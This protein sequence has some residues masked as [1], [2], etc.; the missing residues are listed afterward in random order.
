LAKS[1]LL[2]LI[3]EI[4]QIFEPSRH[5][6]FI[7]LAVNS[8][9][10]AMGHLSVPALRRLN[11]GSWLTTEHK[12]K[13]R[14]IW[15]RR[16][17]LVGW[18]L[19]WCTVILLPGRFVT[20]D[21]WDSSYKL[22]IGNEKS[23][24]RPWAGELLYAAI[25][26]RALGPRE[27][28]QKFRRHGFEERTMSGLSPTPL[29]AY[30]FTQADQHTVT[31]TG[32]VP[33]S[34]LRIDLPPGS[35]WRDGGTPGLVLR[36]ELLATRGPAGALSAAIAAND[37]FS[38]EVWIRPA[39]LSQSGPARIIG[40]SDSILSRNF[41]LSQEEDGLV[42][43]V[44]NRFNGPNGSDYE[45]H[46]RGSLLRELVHVVATYDQGVSSIFRNGQRLGPIVDQREPSY[47]LRLGGTKPLS[48]GA[49]A[50]L[51]ALSL[52]A[53]S[54]FVVGERSQAAVMMRMFLVGYSFLLAPVALSAFLPISVPLSLQM[55]FG[56]AL[57]LSWALLTYTANRSSSRSRGLDCRSTNL[58]EWE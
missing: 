3:L 7:D 46:A 14:S 31:P 18:G 50:L 51:A 54:S 28:E 34:N 5:P 47:L 9:G 55:W 23:G 52:L 48:A 38:V 33:T 32:S 39:N 6:R 35:S 17:L 36:G 57:V 27:V 37:A 19:S 1:L 53:I 21:E 45:L 24:D 56:P 11:R 8:I 30:D 10:L 20:L 4:G 42:F 29:A 43:R 44:R 2:C 40:I 22:F 49:A 26:D 12:P 15:L 58:T 25:Y 41:T 13:V 16:G